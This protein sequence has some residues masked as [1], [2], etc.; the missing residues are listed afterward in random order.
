MVPPHEKSDLHGQ[1]ALT[2]LMKLFPMLT[3]LYQDL[4]L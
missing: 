1:W 4:G 2:R 3:L